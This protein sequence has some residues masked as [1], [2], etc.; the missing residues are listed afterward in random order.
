MKNVNRSEADRSFQQGLKEYENDRFT[1]SLQLWKKSL[2]L[3]HKSQDYPGEARTLKHLGVVSCVL[4]NYVESIQFWQQYLSII[5]K[6]END[7]AD[8]L[9]AYNQ[10]GNIFYYLEDYQQAINLFTRG[11]EL[12]HS[13][14]PRETESWN[15]ETQT[16]LNKIG[17]CHAGLKDYEKAIIFYQ[18]S[19]EFARELQ[20]IQAQGWLFDDLGKA[21][22]SLKHYP[23]AISYYQE[24]LSIATSLQNLQSQEWAL[25]GLGDVYYE[26][27][28]HINALKSY[29]QLLEIICDAKSIS[30]DSNSSREGWA[31]CK[32][33]AAYA[34]LYNHSKANEYFLRSLSIAQTL[35]ERE[36][37]GQVFGRLGNVYVD[38]GLY[39]EAIE[40][41]KW[42][43]EISQELGRLELE[44]Q[45]LIDLGNAYYFKASYSSAID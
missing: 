45:A 12:A 15:K 8:R 16:S 25:D 32:L 40:H 24:S 37:E 31:L 39:D 33:G 36:L 23:Q 30:D 22:A 5:K 41:H 21:Y 42:F 28:D 11:L 44:A 14:E 7:S 27:D 3:Y 17:L 2:E 43:L 6:L 4:E 35:K 20:D 29:H 19:L 1:S 34:A 9:Y 10:I 18:K 26:S 38:M 13:L